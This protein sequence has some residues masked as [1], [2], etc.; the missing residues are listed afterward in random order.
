MAFPAR[1]PAVDALGATLGLVVFQGA[2]GRSPSDG[3]V[4]SASL[5]VGSGERV[6]REAAS[7]GAA[8]NPA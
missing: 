2:E 5:S 8:A 6:A 7:A 1:T 4:G 3:K